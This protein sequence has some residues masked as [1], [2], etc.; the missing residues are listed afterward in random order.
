MPAKF[1]PAQILQIIAMRKAGKKQAFICKEMD[2]CPETVSKYLRDA[3]T[4]EIIKRAPAAGL[5]ALE[6]TGLRIL[7]D[8]TPELTAGT[9]LSP[10][11]FA[12]VRKLLRHFAQLGDTKPMTATEIQQH[13]AFFG[14]GAL[15]PTLLLQIQAAF[16]PFS[17]TDCGHTFAYL[18]SV[19]EV[20]CSACGT[21]YARRKS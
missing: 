7:L 17:C 4:D 13:R 20:F 16:T 5:T 19:A 11:D 12:S 10:E 14:V 3:K 1:S 21:R 2:A 8:L 18:T 9:Q 15:D 6:I